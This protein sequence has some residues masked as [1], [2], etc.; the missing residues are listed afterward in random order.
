MSNNLDGSPEN[1]A[2]WIQT[3]PKGHI[4]YNS[5]YITFLTWQNYRNEEQIIVCQGLRGGG[6]EGG[7]ENG[8]AIKA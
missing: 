2:E 5:T 4:L 6:N 1:Y 8:V 3:I 7:R